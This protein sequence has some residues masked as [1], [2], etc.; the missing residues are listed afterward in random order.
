VFVTKS[1]AA[2]IAIANDLANDAHQ[3]PTSP[4]RQQPQ[5]FSSSNPSML[6]RRAPLPVFRESMPP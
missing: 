2:V 6:L 1:T 4:L 5:N 3:R